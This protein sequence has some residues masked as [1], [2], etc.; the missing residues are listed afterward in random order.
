[1][2]SCHQDQ[3]CHGCDVQYVQEQKQDANVGNSIQAFWDGHIGGVHEVGAAC[4]CCAHS[5]NSPSTCSFAAPTVNCRGRLLTGPTLHVQWCSSCF[6]AQTDMRSGLLSYFSLTLAAAQALA[7]A[8]KTCPQLPTMLMIMVD[9]LTALAY[10]W[11]LT[12][13]LLQ[14]MQVS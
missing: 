6:E 2:C 3:Q 14:R 11:P 7:T 12:D 10:V 9:G 13:P 5:V 4:S 1:M 8:F